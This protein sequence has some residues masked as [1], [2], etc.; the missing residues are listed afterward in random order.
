MTA[1]DIATGDHATVAEL[2]PGEITMPAVSDGTLYVAQ[3]DQ[4]SADRYQLIG[5]D[6]VTGTER[7]HRRAPTEN[8]LVVGGVEGATIYPVSEDGTA[9]LESRLWVIGS[10]DVDVIV[11]L[12]AA[13]G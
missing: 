13:G 11:A 7:W 1:F 9:Y 12:I 4:A 3:G 5:I 2:G 6:A 8:R 10:D